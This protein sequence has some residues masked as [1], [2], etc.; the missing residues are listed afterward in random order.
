MNLSNACPPFSYTAHEFFFAQHHGI[1][2]SVEASG[3]ALL[4]TAGHGKPSKVTVNRGNHAENRNCNY[5][6]LTVLTANLKLCTQDWGSKE[7]SRLIP[8]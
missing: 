7:K 6:V 5:L 2:R 4:V 1:G 8:Q 3:L